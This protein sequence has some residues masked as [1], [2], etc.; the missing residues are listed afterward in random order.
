M[1]TKALQVVPPDEAKAVA[2]IA[3]PQY[4][5][6]DRFVKLGKSVANNWISLRD[7]LDAYDEHPE[8][9]TP[10]RIEGCREFLDRVK[11]QIAEWKSLDQICNSPTFYEDNGNGHLKRRIIEEQ[12][13]LLLGSFPNAGPHNPAVYS[14]MLVEE[15]VAAGPS[16]VALE[17]TCREIRRTKNFAPTIAE[18][19]K[20][21]KEK[22]TESAEAN[23]AC[24]DDDETSD[25]F[26]RMESQI[27]EAEAAYQ[28]ARTKP[29]TEERQ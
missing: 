15:I 14:G 1:K 26:A 12:V 3:K 13:A 28:E 2:P 6:F 9:A 17:A 27:R 16:A 29:K 20:I 19:L 22:E 10:E 23:D 11:Q 5:D 8:K 4:A 21:L 18:V 24:C 7:A 25:Y